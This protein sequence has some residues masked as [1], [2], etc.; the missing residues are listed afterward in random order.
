MYDAVFLNGSVGVG[1]TTAGEA[2]AELLGERGIPSAF[3]DVDALRRRHPRRS[4]D[5]WAANVAL[6]GLRAVAANYREDGVRVV[7]ASGVVETPEEVARTADALGGGHTLFVRLTADVSVVASRLERRHFDDPE[8]LRWHLARAPELDGV[9]D[10]AGLSHGLVLDSGTLAAG[11]LATRIAE[12]LA[13]GDDSVG[14]VHVS[15]RFG[16]PIDEL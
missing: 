16:A 14:E 13:D 3:I 6:R 2:L 15:H 10:G 5:P 1:K 11:E 4:D 12:R 8:G 9:L 7:V